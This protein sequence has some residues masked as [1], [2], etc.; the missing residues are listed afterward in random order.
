VAAL[1]EREQDSYPKGMCI[2]KVANA[3][4]SWAA[5]CANF[6]GHPEEKLRLYGVTGTNGKTSVTYIMQSILKNAGLIGTVGLWQGGNPIKIP[7]DTSTTP[8][9]PEL[10]QIFELMHKNGAE[11]VIMEV[12]SHA[13]ALHKME[14]LNFEA[15]MF[16]NLTQDHL[17]F[18]GTMENYL[19]AK[20]KLFGQCRFGVVNV[21]DKYSPQIMSIGS[22]ERWITYGIANECDIRA[23]HIEDRADGSAFDIEIEGKLENFYLPVKSRFNI[24]NTLACIGAALVTGISVEQIRSGLADFEGVPGRI[25]NIPNDKGL[26]VLVDYAHSPDGLVNIINEVRGFTTGKLITLF[27]CGGDRDADKRPKMG[28]IAGTLSDHCI[29]TSD[30]PRS[31]PPDAIIAQIEEGIKDTGCPYD[32]SA[33]RREAIFAGIAMLEQG[34]A[35]IIA[36]KGHEDYQ[37]I[38]TETLHFDDVEV[39]KEA[40]T[41]LCR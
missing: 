33:D 36:G 34:D 9:P 6:Y 20:A 37:I 14:G 27:G 21:D 23:I 25:Q 12:S 31:E 5:M 32:K 28:R 19:A 15:A 16:T 26:Q 24:Y 8:D 30:N 13:L 10:M 35:L 41:A 40:L 2:L 4:K 38:G 1:I 29:L 17:D 7:F 39:A 11:D 3:R 22:P 18:H